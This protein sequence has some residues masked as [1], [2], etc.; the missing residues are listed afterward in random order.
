MQIAALQDDY[1]VYHVARCIAAAK[2]FVKWKIKTKM[3]FVK[4]AL[5]SI[6]Q[7]I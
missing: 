7:P 1:T 6:G 2:Q 3:F 5:A 4:Q